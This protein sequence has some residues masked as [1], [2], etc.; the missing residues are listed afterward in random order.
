M[1]SQDV[2]EPLRVGVTGHRILTDLRPV[3]DSIDAALAHIRAAYSGRPLSVLS[4]LA[5]GADRL[6]AEA[7]L[8]TPGGKLAAVIPFDLDDYASDFGPDGSP[9]RIHFGCLLKRAARV[10]QLPSRATR[11]EGYEQ[12][13]HHVVDHGD[14]LLAIWDGQGPQGQ[15]GTAEIVARARAEGKPLIIICA[16]NRKPGTHEPTT[17]GEEQGKLVIE[18]LPDR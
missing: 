3:V 11:A 16:G 17:L 6:V 1:A 8:R 13:G 14:V 7:V 5:E 10:I 9:S 2:S 18:G 15:G 4:A 12:G